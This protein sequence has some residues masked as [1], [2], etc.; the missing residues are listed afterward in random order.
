MHQER[1]LIVP[2]YTANSKGGSKAVSEWSHLH[3]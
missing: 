2:V 1:S 3:L